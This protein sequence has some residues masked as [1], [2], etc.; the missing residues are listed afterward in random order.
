MPLVPITNRATV[1]RMLT[2]CAQQSASSKSTS[3]SPSSS[4][5]LPQ[6]S[7]GGS[8]VVV[9]RVLEVVELTAVD[10]VE[11]LVVVVGPGDVVDVLE[12]VVVVRVLDDVVV[13][14]DVDVVLVALDVL[15][16]EELVVVVVV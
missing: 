6:L 15:V 4:M 1:T 2:G 10:D 5:Q 14:R 8:G 7:A 13:L 16:V 9:G 12:L 3:W 11:L